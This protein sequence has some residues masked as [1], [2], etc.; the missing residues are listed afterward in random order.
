MDN[1]IAIAV[2]DADIHKH[3]LEIVTEA[4]PEFLLPVTL[5]QSEE[6]K[7]LLY[8]REGMTPVSRFG[9]G[10]DISLGGIFAVITGYIRCL[11]EARDRMLNT[12]L[13]SSDPENG[14][15][16][17]QQDSCLGVSPGL[18]A[19]SGLRVL[20]VWGADTVTDENEKICRIAAALSRRERVM[21]AKAG[22][23]R[24]IEII[25][26]EN[27]SLLNCLKAAERVCREW[28]RIVQPDRP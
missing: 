24:L 19:S 21:G 27:P 7:A 18:S 22:T 4:K 20:T 23:E 13:V 3:E 28:N 1:I 6:R 2:S 10:M 5:A 12:C 9:E 16:V 15:F 14:V 8:S 17:A 26:S 11:L 25:R